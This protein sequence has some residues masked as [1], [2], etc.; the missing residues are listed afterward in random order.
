MAAKDFLINIKYNNTLP[1]QQHGPFF[2]TDTNPLERTV[3]GSS[4]YR[5]STLEK[6]YIWQPHFGPD[7]GLNLDLIDQDAILHD[8]SQ[9]VPL[10]PADK[11]YLSG[12]VEKSRGA[13]LGAEAK[14]WWLRNTTYME[15]NLFKNK[16]MVAVKNGEAG[17][18]EETQY[19][20]PNTLENIENSFG[21]VVQTVETIRKQATKREMLWSI[22]VLPTD[23]SEFNMSQNCHSLVRFDEDPQNVVEQQLRRDG[24]PVSST[25]RKI[26]HS[27][28]SNI[29][30]SKKPNPKAHKNFDSSLVAPAV[31]DREGE[32]ESELDYRWVK[33]YRMEPQDMGL[34]DSFMILI[35]SDCVSSSSNYS[36]VRAANFFPVSTRIDLKKI[37]FEDATPLQC[38]VT[39]R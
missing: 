17:A 6:N 20:E 9:S 13:T 26:E 15:N 37:N 33:D 4:K 32:D 3:A 2:K 12:A 27:I 38:S 28:I 5:M 31:G 29:R 21:K 7:I 35:G 36:A 11:R 19:S 1:K 8:K 16:T 34:D 24:D 22:P 14:P 25:K 18:Q 10:D 23:F 30:V 39:R